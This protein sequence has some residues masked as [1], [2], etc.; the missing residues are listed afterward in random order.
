MVLYLA[1]ERALGKLPEGWQFQGRWEESEEWSVT[2]APTTV[3]APLT[4]NP[5]TRI[6]LRLGA[7]KQRASCI[8]GETGGPALELTLEARKLLCV[9]FAWP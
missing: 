6:G 3:T 8:A 7:L 2:S 4:E 1:D 9:Q 5:V